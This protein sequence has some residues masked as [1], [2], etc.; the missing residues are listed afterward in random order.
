MRQRFP[1][2]DSFRFVAACIVLCCHIE[3]QKHYL[4]LPTL[5]SIDA[6]YEIGKM[7][8]TSF[9]VMSGFLITHL[10]LKEKEQTND[11]RLSW[12]YIRR[13]LR[14]WP[15]YY[16][17]TFIAFFILPLSDAG[18]VPAQSE[19]LQQQFL[20][21]LFLYIIL[22]PQFIYLNGLPVPGAEQLWT[23]GTE[24]IFYFLWP[25]VL[26]FSKNPLRSTIIC[27]GGWLLTKFILWQGSAY[28]LHADTNIPY[29]LF[30]IMYYN[31]IECLMLGSLAAIGLKQNTYWFNFIS[32][33]IIFLFIGI[34]ILLALMAASLQFGAFDYFWYAFAFMLILSY[35]GTRK[36]SQSAALQSFSRYLGHI[37]Y[38][39]YIWHFPVVL[40][41]LH[42]SLRVW[43]WSPTEIGSNAG[44]YLL[45]FAGT[46]TSAILS[47]HLIEKPFLRLQ[48]RFRPLHSDH[49]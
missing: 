10:L 30:S 27:G 36:P 42:Y 28:L 41:V 5:I 7:T 17:L 2:F 18:Y 33:N 44:I 47:Y 3:I 23:I 12:F 29:T 37:T 40:I 22:M 39:L 4:L 25:V 43:H 45:V 8:V 11:I 16:L 35:T 46:L 34:F 24:E 6:V 14:I 26:L 31:K 9:F 21:K 38:S 32:K 20:P 19:E 15:L 13:G 1:G 49:T 48:N